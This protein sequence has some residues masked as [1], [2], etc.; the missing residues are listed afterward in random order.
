[1]LPLSKAILSGLLAGVLGLVV[2]LVPFGLALEESVGLE[3]LFQ[4]RGVRQPPSDVVIV[5]IDRASAARLDVPDNPR[6]WPRSLH[7][8][9]MENLTQAGVAAI[10]FDIIFDESRSAADDQ[11]FAEA[12]RQA[13][14]VVLFAS[15]KRETVSFTGEGGAVAG[16]LH[17]ETLVPPLPPLVQAAAA[18]APFPL[19]KIPVKVSQ[20]WTFKTGA[21]GIPTLPVVMLQVFA[22]EAYDDFLRLVEKVSPS[23]AAQLPRD[24]EAILT[25]TGVVSLVRVL[26]DIF[27]HEPLTA[28]SMLGALQHA[29]PFSVDVKKRQLLT[30]LIRMYQNTNSQYLNFYGPPGTV[31]TVPYYQVLQLQEG[32]ALL[33]RRKK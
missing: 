25:T 22:L 18:F 6:K 13:R 30:S 2:S 9:L 31:T 14:Q 8:R 32:V 19:P 27:V 15:L 4:L 11:A 17:M 24:K 1:M 20:Y 28:E 5:S 7:A 23:Q 3:V 26:R 21:G 12:I 10:A 16:A 29:S 33:E